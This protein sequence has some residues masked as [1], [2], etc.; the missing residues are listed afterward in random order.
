M[1]AMPI[2]IRATRRPTTTPTTS[3]VWSL[4]SAESVTNEAEE[5]LKPACYFSVPNSSQLNAAKQKFYVQ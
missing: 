2:T 1:Y 4:S 3:L 5:A